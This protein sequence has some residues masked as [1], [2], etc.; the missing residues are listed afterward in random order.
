MMVV[1]MNNMNL[2]FF[3]ENCLEVPN[4]F[5]THTHTH[6]YKVQAQA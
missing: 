6:L 1:E 5:V 2:W 4:N 3:N